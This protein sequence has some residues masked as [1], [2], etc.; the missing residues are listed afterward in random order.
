MK[1]KICGYE[2][3]ETDIKCPGCDTSVEELKQNNNIMSNESD[4]EKTIPIEIPSTE[5]P[6]SDPVE[7]KVAEPVNQPATENVGESE[8]AV[9]APVENTSAPVS[10]EEAT[11][12]EGADVVIG[13]P[14]DSNVSVD[15]AAKEEVKEE[16]KEPKKEK[17]KGGAG[18]V[19]L[20]I[21]ILIILAIAGAAGYF[22]LV[23]G[24]PSAVLSRAMDS[25]LVVTPSNERYVNI[26]ADVEVSKE[27]TSKYTIDSKVDL[28]NLV[29]DTNI[30]VA[31]EPTKNIAIL[32]D[33]ENSYVKFGDIYTNSIK[34]EDSLL[35]EKLNYSQYVP[36]V[37][38]MNN[39]KNIISEL[40]NVLPKV[41]DESKL[42]REFTTVTIDQK[43]MGV[44][45]IGYK[46]DQ[47]DTN[48]L[49]LN[50]G[51]EFKKNTAIMTNLMAI[52]TLPQ[53]EVNELIDG[54]VKDLSVN[55][56]EFNLYTDYLTNNYY[57]AEVVV[58]GINNIKLTAKFDENNKV[59]SLSI[60]VGTTQID[61]TNNYKH[62]EVLK[63]VNGVANKYV[64]DITYTAIPAVQVVVPEEFT[65]YYVLGK[66]T[67]E[68]SISTDK[69]FTDA[70]NL[71]VKDANIVYVAPEAPVDE[72]PVVEPTPDETIIDEQSEAE[73]Q[74]E[75]DN[76]AEANTQ[77]E[78]DNQ[79]TE[80]NTPTTQE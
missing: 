34:F 21:I 79:T 45:K 23:Y 8:P 14:L 7:E 76:Q 77:T 5:V 56:F 18:K 20:V 11:I 42:T 27:G 44:T 48:K 26:K 73:T 4:L 62:I 63:T 28:T 22:F 29:S 71:I 53:P 36:Y 75:T 31:G 37:T 30:I 51:N 40:K 78:V 35:Y 50:L 59:E 74:P 58:K 3:S 15:E 47:T 17:K 46:L 25:A 68:A 55:G 6:A 70:Y 1:C 72:P 16:V 52:Y 57:M 66:E 24:K 41:I 2:L 32:N 38:H 65:E 61:I 80:D 69:A 12:Y 43:N 67:L 19:V 54:F 9:E 33:G 39:V 60:L 64:L 49:M 13:A 10:S